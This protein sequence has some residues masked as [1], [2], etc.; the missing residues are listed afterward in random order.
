MEMRVRKGLSWLVAALGA[1][2][3]VGSF[4][5]AARAAEEP[6]PTRFNSKFEFAVFAQIKEGEQAKKLGQTPA[7]EPLVIPAC[8]RWWVEPLVAPGGQLDM[9]ALRREVQDL[10]IPGLGLANTNVGDAELLELKDLAALETLILAGS[11]VTD[12]GL[13]HLKDLK[14]LQSLNL[15]DTKVT[16]AGLAH[17]KDLNQLRSLNLCDTK[18]TDV[19][20]A[21]L[22]DLNQL[23]TL[24]LGNARVTDAGLP[25]LKDLKQLQM[26]FLIG[27]QVTDAGLPHLKDLKQLQ[28]LDLQSTKVTDA[29]L[30]LLRLALPALLKGDPQ[31]QSRSRKNLNELAKACFTYLNEFG[32]NRV[33][34]KSTAE[35]IEK[36]VVDKAVLV[37]LSDPDPPA[38]SNG[39]PCSYVLCFDQYP[40]R[41]FRDDFP[42]NLMMAWERMAFEQGG[43]SVIFFDSHVEF[44]Q[45]ARFQ[46]LLL[47]LYKQVKKIPK[48]R[49]AGEK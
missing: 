6:A 1:A 44:V 48:R 17:L 19:G 37:A 26:L 33:Y 38:L 16:D 32:D 28:R 41:E 4:D 14:Q 29:G 5:S 47:E 7:P 24:D 12:A 15:H 45:E 23:Q 3:V 13:A 21:H 27:T 42:P 10:K 25:H 31:A 43:R 35:L 2:W 8:R 11:R 34:P 39:T 40:N 46:E 18:V 36:K 9:A 22:K 30:A 49:G 20:L